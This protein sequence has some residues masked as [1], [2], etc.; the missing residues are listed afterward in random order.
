MFSPQSFPL[1]KVNVIHREWFFYSLIHQ[2]LIECLV[3]ARH[4]ASWG[5]F[6]PPGPSIFRSYLIR[7]SIDPPIQ[8]FHDLFMYSLLKRPDLKKKEYVEQIFGATSKSFL[9]TRYFQLWTLTFWKN[10]ILFQEIDLFCPPE[11]QVSYC[12]HSN[13]TKMLVRRCLKYF[14]I[15][16]CFLRNSCSDANRSHS[17][18]TTSGPKMLFVST[19]FM[20]DFSLT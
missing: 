13:T 14:A 1:K 7:N 5:F 17:R 12:V 3:D 18:G 15:W 2:A 8:G 19:D 9:P 6:S 20:M 10:L 4:W 16:G 11:L